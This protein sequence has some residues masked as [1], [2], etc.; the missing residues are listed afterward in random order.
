MPPEMMAQIRKA[1]E[2]MRQQ[3]RNMPAMPMDYPR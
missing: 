2:Q 3:M 1:Q